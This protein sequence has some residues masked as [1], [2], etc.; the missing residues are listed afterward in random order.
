MSQADPTLCM[1]VPMFDASSATKR[2][3][4]IRLRSGAHAESRSSAPVSGRGS[5]PVIESA[6]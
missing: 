4:K 1:S 6:G 2:A 5:T 3:K